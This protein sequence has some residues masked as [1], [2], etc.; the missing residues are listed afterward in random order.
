LA[1]ARPEDACGVLNCAD[2]HHHGPSRCNTSNG[3][4]RRRLRRHAHSERAEWHRRAAL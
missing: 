2:R 4:L 1:R 3:A